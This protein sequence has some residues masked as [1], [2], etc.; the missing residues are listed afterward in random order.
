MRPKF[1][2]VR[3]LSSCEENFRQLGLREADAAALLAIA[4]GTGLGL[5]AATI[6]FRDQSPH[7]AKLQIACEDSAHRLGLVEHD[8][9]LFIETAIAERNGSADPEA[10]ALGGR[11]LVAHPLADYLTLKL[12]EREQHIEGESAHAGGGVERLGN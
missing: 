5:D 2:M 12:G 11:D 1:S 8:F 7:G 6:E 9:E 10:F 4:T 3:R